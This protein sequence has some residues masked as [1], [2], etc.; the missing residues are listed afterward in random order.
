MEEAVLANRNRISFP[1]QLRAWGKRVIGPVLLTVL[2]FW[3]ALGVRGR[4]V[5]EAVSSEPFPGSLE[6]TFGLA[7]AAAI[8]LVGWLPLLG[9][10]M[11]RVSARQ[12]TLRHSVRG[13]LSDALAVTP[14][15]SPAL[16]YVIGAWFVLTELT[17]WVPA[18]ILPGPGRVL[19]ILADEVRKGDLFRAAGTTMGRNGAAL[20]IST[21]MAMIGVFVLGE[22]SVIRRNS[23]PWLRLCAL[24]PPAVLYVFA[25]YLDRYLTWV[26]GFS[27]PGRLLLLASVGFWPL[28]IAGMERYQDISLQLRDEIFVLRVPPL[29]AAWSIKLPAILKSIAPAFQIAVVLIFVVCYHSETSPAENRPAD[30]LGGYYLYN[31]SMMQS[32]DVLVFALFALAGAGLAFLFACDFWVAFVCGE[33]HVAVDQDTGDENND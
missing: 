33:R 27:Q 3:R 19:Q 14:L 20:A 1:P 2:V 8:A 17:A 26:P 7:A 15:F 31:G 25:P 29:T 30:G 11:R 16:P 23:L 22:L 9:P 24:V 4:P 18:E 28:L 12:V 32:W 13:A 21:L 6:F 10:W 5:I